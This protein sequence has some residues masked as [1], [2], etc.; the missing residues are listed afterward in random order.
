M[1]SAV[2]LG[3]TVRTGHLSS[4]RYLFYDLLPTR[5]SP[6]HCGENCIG[7]L[8]DNVFERCSDYI[9]ERHHTH[10][11]AVVEFHHFAFP[12]SQLPLRH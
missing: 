1:H 10:S 4:S 2:A 11:L 12:T 9:G 8:Q 6:L 5:S 3:T 7:H